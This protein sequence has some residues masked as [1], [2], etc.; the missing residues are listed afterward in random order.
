MEMEKRKLNIVCWLLMVLFSTQIPSILA[1]TKIEHSKSLSTLVQE[2]HG[3]MT[4]NGKGDPLKPT[5]V[6]LARGQR[7][8]RGSGGG[9]MDRI[10]HKN[11]GANEAPRHLSLFVVGVS[12]CILQFI[13]S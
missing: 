9:T 5:A 1:H 3:M 4:L 8:G 2:S 6:M 12:F 10:P 13:V 7:G 11:K